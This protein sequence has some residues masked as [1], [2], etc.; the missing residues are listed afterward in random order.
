[1]RFNE[2]N[3]DVDITQASRILR[4]CPISK[5]GR[6]GEMMISVPM[7]F[8]MQEVSVDSGSATLFIEGDYFNRIYHMDPSHIFYDIRLGIHD[9]PLGVGILD[10][11][12]RIFLSIPDHVALQHRI[13]GLF[14]VSREPAQKIMDAVILQAPQDLFKLELLDDTVALE[15]HDGSKRLPLSYAALKRQDGIFTFSPTYL[16][17][18]IAAFR[19]D[20]ISFRVRAIFR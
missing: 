7:S 13:A 6:D 4:L 8:K 17:Q 5:K 1:M 18:K 16:K 11:D 20:Y 3:M 14:T 15:D 19:Y 12:T 10:N 9:D 2:D